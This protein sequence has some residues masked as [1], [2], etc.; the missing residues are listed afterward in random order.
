MKQQNKI[1]DRRDF[2]KNTSLLSLCAA[3][4]LTFSSDSA[5]AGPAIPK[6]GGSRLKVSLN[7]YSFDSLLL[8][9][10][11]D[12]N[13]GMSLMEL[14]DFCALHNFDAIDSTAY[15]FPG[16]PKV[17]SNACLNDFKRRA[18]H[19][20]LE[21]SGTGV[22]N[23]FAQPDKAKRAADVALVKEW[24][25]AAARLGAPVIRV[26]AGTESAGY[27]RQQV[28][29]WMVEDLRQCVEYGKN[30]G[31][32]VGVQNHGDFLKTADQTIEVV[33]RVD[34]EWFGVIV[35]TGN[36][37]T[38]DPYQDVAR[39][40]PYAVNWQ[41]KEQVRKG[42]RMDLKRLIQV[43]R[44]GGYRG[45][46]PIETLV[47]EGKPYDPKIL[48]PEFLNKVREAIGTGN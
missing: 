12:K 13:A 48:I 28:L 18:F 11:K 46:L 10:L 24:I 47:E 36:F 26:F 5:A 40:L 19:L 8:A 6:T 31:V 2:I 35:D 41:V 1:Q 27:T 25:E 20:G 45:C 42:V 14:L 32:M 9:N 23:N 3:T 43:I 16:Y 38:E 37:Q 44:A 17:P 22:R 15:Y 21:I 4:G 30:Y 39:V 7:A 33:K 29:D 34:S